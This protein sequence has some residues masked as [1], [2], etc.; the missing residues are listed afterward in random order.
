MELDPHNSAGTFSFAQICH[1]FRIKKETFFFS[2][3]SFII[4]YSNFLRLSKSRYSAKERFSMEVALPQ[5]KKKKKKT[6]V[7]QKEGL[8]D[9]KCNFLFEG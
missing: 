9:L 2:L 8:L 4:P 1:L 3:L 7:R 5:S 6:S